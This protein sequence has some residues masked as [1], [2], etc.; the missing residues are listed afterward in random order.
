MT[1]EALELIIGAG[2]FMLFLQF[3]CVSYLA[4]SCNGL[5]TTLALVALGFSLLWCFDDYLPNSKGK[6][7][8]AVKRGGTR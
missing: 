8:K 5:W 3:L 2:S 7:K 6:K 1:K 4:E